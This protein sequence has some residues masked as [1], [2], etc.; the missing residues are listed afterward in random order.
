MAVLPR[1]A[2]PARSSGGR[3]DATVRRGHGPS[4]RTRDSE[5]PRARCAQPD[6]SRRPAIQRRARS[7]S[8]ARPGALGSPAPRAIAGSQP[9][10]RGGGREAPP[11]ALRGVSPARDSTTGHPGRS[12]HRTEAS[13]GVERPTAPTPLPLRGAGR[14]PPNLGGKIGR[15]RDSPAWI[16]KA[17]DAA[18]LGPRLWSTHGIAP[19]VSRR[20]PSERPLGCRS[21]SGHTL[22]RPRRMKRRR[23]TGGSPSAQGPSSE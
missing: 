21:P 19:E 12:R 10:S 4:P 8:S 1:R 3:T 11:R 18:S 13:R 17:P 15:S 14:A 9:S 16:S 5:R 22:H 2:P 23:G 20:C 7:Q 6:P